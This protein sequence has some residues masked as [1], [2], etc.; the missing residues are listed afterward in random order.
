MKFRDT[1]F[2]ND[3]LTFMVMVYVKPKNY[4]LDMSVKLPFFMVVYIEGEKGPYLLKV[5]VQGEKWFKMQ[6]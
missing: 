4:L 2:K 6:H 1:F 5:V 3:V